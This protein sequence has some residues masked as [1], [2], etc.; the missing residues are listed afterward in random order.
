MSRT[1]LLNNTLLR[2]QSG[3]LIAAPAPAQRSGLGSAATPKLLSASVR[4][5]HALKGFY[6][7]APLLRGPTWDRSARRP[8]AE[9]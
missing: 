9:C 5:G 4:T 2:K 6:K 7:N 1:H 3:P 8:A